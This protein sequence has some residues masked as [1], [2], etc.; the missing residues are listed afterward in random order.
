MTHAKRKAIKYALKNT[1]IPDVT[2]AER[3]S[4]I[5][6]AFIAGYLSHQNEQAK[7]P[8]RYKSKAAKILLEDFKKR[9]ITAKIPHIIAEA[10]GFTDDRLHTENPKAI[11]AIMC[12]IPSGETTAQV[13]LA[14]NSDSEILKKVILQVAEEFK[15]NPNV[16]TPAV[17]S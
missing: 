7:K 9:N 4:A 13:M 6:N 15:V 2:F 5:Q 1:K 16:I 12:L 17:N 11:F 10:I 3:E 8:K 14:G